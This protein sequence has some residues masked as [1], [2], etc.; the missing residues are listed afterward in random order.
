[1][2]RWAKRIGGVLAGLFLLYL[3][4]AN[5]LLRTGVLRGWLNADEETMRVDWSSAWSPRPGRVVVRDLSLRFQDSD[6]QFLLEIE[7]ASFSVELSALPRRIFRVTGLDGRNASFRMRH[8]YAHAKGRGSRLAAFPSIEGFADPPIRPEPHRDD[9]SEDAYDLWTV[10]LRDVKAT[11]REL[12]IMEVRYAG[13]SEATVA[14]GFFLKPL[15]RLRVAPSSFSMRGGT[16]AIGD[17]TFLAVERGRLEVDVPEYDVRIPTGAEVFREIDAR[18]ELDGAMTNPNVVVE[19]YLPAAGVSVD[20]EDGRVRI[21]ATIRRGVVSPSTRVEYETKRLSVRTADLAIAG[22]AGVR[23]SVEDGL[24]AEMKIPSATVVVAERDAARV[25]PASLRC[26]LD[27]SDLSRSLRPRSASLSVTSVRV[28]DAAR[29]SRLLP[30]P[31]FLRSGSA[32]AALRADYD[33]GTLT[34]RFDVV[35]D[36]VRLAAGTFDATTSG[37]AWL[38]VKS[39]DA[40]RAVAF[41]G[42]G[43]DLRDADVVIEGSRERGFVLRADVQ[44]ALA[45]FGDVTD[46]DAGVVLRAGP[47]DRILRLL[48]GA[49][50]LP[51]GIAAAPAGPE[52]TARL[53][54]GT[55]RGDPSVRVLEA[56]NGDLATRGFWSSSRKSS[57]GAFLFEL[58]PLR[59]GVAI[60][61]GEAKVSPGVASDWLERKSGPR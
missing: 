14:G 8:A 54:L 9:V 49:L 32:T 46:V 18:V 28:D 29:L 12:W 53:R 22:P 3:V 52:A 30:R 24:A 57:S 19:T 60:L 43:V 61:D 23:G 34:G 5:V 21:A 37:K 25:G 59:A 13:A 41:G 55:V 39:K 40:S 56:R 42:S 6:V 50:S 4:A 15:R 10:D 45:R 20:D 27:G 31:L 47:G 26:V 36:R 58:G 38:D 17:R 1:M 2:R 44:H 16:L 7:E 35:L 11:V 51:K 33:G 48:G